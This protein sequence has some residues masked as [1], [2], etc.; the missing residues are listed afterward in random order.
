MENGY[1][2]SM[3]CIEDPLTKGKLWNSYYQIHRS[4]IMSYSLIRNTLW[5][6]FEL[7]IEIFDEIQM[8][9][10]RIVKLFCFSKAL[11]ILICFLNGVFFT[12]ILLFSKN[13]N[14]LFLTF[15]ELSMPLLLETLFAWWTKLHIKRK[16]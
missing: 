11:P 16:Q 2:P 13:I 1:R 15:F 6:E 10:K 7:F 3:L 12:M 8:S 5:V 4:M 14:D 9:F